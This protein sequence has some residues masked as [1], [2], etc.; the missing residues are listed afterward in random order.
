MNNM[1][2]RDFAVNIRKINAFS[3]KES[4]RYNKYILLTDLE[5]ITNGNTHSSHSTI[6]PSYKTEKKKTLT[7]PL[8]TPR[9]KH[10]D[11]LTTISNLMAVNPPLPK[12]F[13]LKNELNLNKQHQKGFKSSHNIYISEVH[14]TNYSR[15]KSINE[16]LVK[17]NPLQF[18]RINSSIEMMR[19]KP[20]TTLGDDID[21]KCIITQK[22]RL[23]DNLC[24][25]NEKLKEQVMKD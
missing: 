18:S 7:I 4:G 22:N 23:I 17:E 15:S 1:T 2:T 6:S 19:S 24:H 25:D 10:N 12:N 13:N 20:N 9:F 16:G 3:S 21:Y 8:F 14:K 11:K 5:T